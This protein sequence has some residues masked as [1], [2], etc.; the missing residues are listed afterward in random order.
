MQLNMMAK[1]TANRSGMITAK[2][3]ADLTSIVN[4]MIIAPNTTNGDRSKSRSPSVSALL[5]FRTRRSPLARDV[6]SAMQTL[7][8]GN[9]AL[10]FK[11]HL[12]FAD[13]SV[14][15]IRPK[16]EICAFKDPS[17]RI[18]Q[19]GEKNYLSFRSLYHSCPP[20]SDRRVSGRQHAPYY[21]YYLPFF[22]P[23]FTR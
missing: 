6:F 2:T 19:V 16:H 4:A 12:V 3:R 18:T 10:G 7:S 5:L 20:H 22:R 21:C 1:T 14:A 15:A 23:G 13:V 17:A 9:Y 11:Q 8:L